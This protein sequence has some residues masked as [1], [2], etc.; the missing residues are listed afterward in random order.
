MLTTMIVCLLHSVASFRP[1][2]T[3]FT[4][5]IIISAKIERKMRCPKYFTESLLRSVTTTMPA[6]VE[7]R[8]GH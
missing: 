3:N 1:I 2:R 5:S 6:R 4:K 7:K 8:S